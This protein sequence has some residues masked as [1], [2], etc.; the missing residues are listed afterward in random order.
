[1]GGSA[2]V[3]GGG[4]ALLN[5]LLS[6]NSRAADLSQDVKDLSALSNCTVGVNGSGMV[7]FICFDL[8]GG[9]NL[10]GSNVMVG[11]AGGQND[12]FVGT[13]QHGAAEIT[14][15]WSTDAAGIAF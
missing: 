1:M 5:L 10:A 15:L 2:I 8:A 4:S 12:P 13:S 6:Q 14:N 3:T 9:A 11:G 7:P